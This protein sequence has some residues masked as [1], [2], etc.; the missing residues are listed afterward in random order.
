MLTN[1]TNAL[2][3]QS[4]HKQVSFKA[5]LQCLQIVQGFVDQSINCSMLLDHWQWALGSSSSSL[6]PW[7]WQVQITEQITNGN[8]RL[9]YYIA[10]MGRSQMQSEGTVP[11]P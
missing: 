10:K 5:C 3:H 6:W 9:Q 1:A 11:E 8:S 4:I 2:K 7:T